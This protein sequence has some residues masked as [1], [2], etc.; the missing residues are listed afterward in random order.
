MKPFKQL[1]LIGCGLMGGSF[2]LALKRA[3]MVERVVGYSKS[4]RTAEQA[5]RMG[6]IDDAAASVLQTVPG[7]DLVLIAV[8]VAA[9]A[10][11]FKAIQFGLHADALVLDVGSTKQNVID[12]AQKIFGAAL[13]N[14]VPSHPIAGKERAGVE[15][16]QA[17]LYAGKRVI[18][19][20]TEHTHASATTLATEVWQGI[21]MQVSTMSA[22]CHDQML[23]AVSHLP[24]LAAF[25]Y[26][27]SI[28]EQSNAAQ[29]L[30]MAG[31]GFQDFTRIAASSPDVWVDILLA[32]REE[33]LQQSRHMLASL[34][35]FEDAMRSNNANALRQ[36]I[37]SASKVRGSW[38]LNQTD[39]TS[40]V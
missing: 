6:V 34:A 16:A 10:D 14:F 9:T 12:V 37:T 38:A 23:A 30:A 32:N 39:L 25:A 2:A 27:H 5:K 33:V 29:L 1:G 18:L 28:A 3:K 7:A 26:M 19:T 24:H 4:S 15:A 20:P 13:P 35:R 17:D 31:P 11:V 22:E 36:L 40:N 21:G 8:P